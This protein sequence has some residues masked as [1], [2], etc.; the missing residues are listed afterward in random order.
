[1]VGDSITLGSAG[2]H[3]WRYRMWR[4]LNARYEGPYRIVGPRHTVH[5]PATGTDT[6]YEYADPAFLGKSLRPRAGTGPSAHLAGWG[7]GFLHMAPVIRDEVAAHRPGLLLVHLGLIDLGFYTG[8]EDTEANMRRFVA[9]ARSAN[10]ALRMAVLPVVPNIR[11]LTDPGFAAQCEEMN[12]R[13]AKAAAELDSPASPLLLAARPEGW[14]V[15]GDTHDGTHPNARGEH[16][17]AKAFADALHQAW[18]IGGP[19]GTVAA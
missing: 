10:P 2:E 18:G 9:E 19:Y 1:M 6:S 17:L 11:A 14:D 3:T 5:D 12:E 8:P 7:E 4:H 16:R 13:L 15:D